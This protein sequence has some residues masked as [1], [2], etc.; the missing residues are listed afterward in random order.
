MF[1]HLSKAGAI[2]F[3]QGPVVHHMPQN[4]LKINSSA[5]FNITVLY[6]IYTG[7]LTKCQNVNQPVKARTFVVINPNARKAVQHQLPLCVVFVGSRL[8]RHFDRW[9]LDSPRDL[10]HGVAILMLYSIPTHCNQNEAGRN[11][12]LV[13][14]LRNEC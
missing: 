5:M 12:S 9:G 4:G 13:L 1:N 6:F 2:Y 14:C 7:F 3:L 11:N 8:T 10:N